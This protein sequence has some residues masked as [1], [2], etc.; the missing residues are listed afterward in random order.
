L[1]SK[2]IEPQDKDLR[3][4]YSVVRFGW[5]RPRE[6]FACYDSTLSLDIEYIRANPALPRRSLTGQEV[7]RRTHGLSSDALSLEYAGAH[8]D[9]ADRLLCQHLLALL[10]VV[11]FL[12]RRCR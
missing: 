8:R 5:K 12:A 1:E 11:Q 4:P 10:G 3:L 2:G 7:L 9:L 6:N